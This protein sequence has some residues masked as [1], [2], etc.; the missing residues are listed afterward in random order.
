MN[1]DFDTSPLEEYTSM[2]VAYF[3]D[4]KTK[5]GES[6]PMTGYSEMQDKLANDFKQVLNKLCKNGTLR[7]TKVDNEPMFEFTPPR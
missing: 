7:F 5:S 4:H 3:I 1:T 2:M 6:N